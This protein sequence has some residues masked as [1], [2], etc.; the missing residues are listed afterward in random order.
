MSAYP[1]RWPNEDGLIQELRL[2]Y[3]GI[4][5]ANDSRALVPGPNSEVR[6]FPAPE[7]T[8]AS[9][10]AWSTDIRAAQLERMTPSYVLEA[11]PQQ[12]EFRGW[13]LEKFEELTAVHAEGKRGVLE[14]ATRFAVARWTQLLLSLIHI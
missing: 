12:T 4:Q 10:Q 11:V 14:D 6:E 3:Q 5:T 1:D 8:G 9:V 13:N 2:Q 7:P